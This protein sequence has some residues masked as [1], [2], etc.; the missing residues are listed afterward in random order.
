MMTEQQDWKIKTTNRDVWTRPTLLHI[1]LF[2]GR[3]PDNPEDP[4]RIKVEL[5]IHTLFEVIW[6]TIEWDL[7]KYIDF[8]DMIGDLA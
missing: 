3:K 1:I 6:V 8:Q 5:R 4:W 2:D 7:A